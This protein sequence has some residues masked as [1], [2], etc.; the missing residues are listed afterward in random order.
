MPPWP[1]PWQLA[2]CNA[3]EAGKAVGTGEIVA[4][5][6]DMSSN[7]HSRAPGKASVFGQIACPMRSAPTPL[8]W[9]L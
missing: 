7:L 9:R 4:D 1:G 8:G 5:D 2:P 6:H 3:D